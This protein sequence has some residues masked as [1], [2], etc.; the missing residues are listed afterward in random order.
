VTIASRYAPSHRSQT[1]ISRVLATK[2]LA[3]RLVKLRVTL[4]AGARKALVN[5]LAHHR[6]LTLILS[7]LATVP[8]MNSA[9]AIVTS[10]LVL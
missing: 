5:A 2:L 1:R 7:G 9:T 4:P 10:R 8:R 3:G 6:H